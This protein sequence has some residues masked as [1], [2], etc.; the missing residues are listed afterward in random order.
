M[1]KFDVVLK[2]C[3]DGNVTEFKSISLTALRHWLQR[4]HP[5]ERNKNEGT[6]VKGTAKRR[7]KEVDVKLL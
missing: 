1:V 4:A 2:E 6:K 5:Y 3:L 7:K